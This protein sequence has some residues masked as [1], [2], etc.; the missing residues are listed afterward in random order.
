MDAC[1]RRDFVESNQQST[2]LTRQRRLRL[3]RAYLLS[4]PAWQHPNIIR[5][6]APRSLER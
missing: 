3:R 2:A 5:S 6:T 1:D 4:G